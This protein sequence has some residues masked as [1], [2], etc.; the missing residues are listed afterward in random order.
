MPKPP[1]QLSRSGLCIRV[2]AAELTIGVA[3]ELTGA[4]RQI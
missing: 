2:G 1:V 3:A 4:E